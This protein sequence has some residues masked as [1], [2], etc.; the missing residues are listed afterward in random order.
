MW[1]SIN[2]DIMVKVPDTPMACFHKHWTLE[3]IIL[4]K[5]SFLIFFQVRSNTVSKSYLEYIML[6]ALTC[7]SQ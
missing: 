6:T 3:Y 5:L 7:K 4:L 2:S 1:V